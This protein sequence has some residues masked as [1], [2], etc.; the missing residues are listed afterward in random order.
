MDSTFGLI[1]VKYTYRGLPKHFFFR[2]QQNL[3]RTGS[4]HRPDHGSDH[5]S[6]HG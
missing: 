2:R 1:D 5:G 6:D 4:N 3:D